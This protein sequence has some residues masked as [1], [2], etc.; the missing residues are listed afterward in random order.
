MTPQ[1]D[2]LVPLMATLF[3]GLPVVA[4]FWIRRRRKVPGASLR[5]GRLVITL[6]V[7]T[8]ALQI[9][10]LFLGFTTLE[11]NRSGC[12]PKLAIFAVLV[13]AYAAILYTLDAKP[14]GGDGA[15]DNV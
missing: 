6:W 7:L 11:G 3:W 10:S 9:L 12:G 13:A 8:F 5:L 4:Y 2:D 14:K 1:C 15:N